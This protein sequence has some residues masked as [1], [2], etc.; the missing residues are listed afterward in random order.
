LKRLNVWLQNPDNVTNLQNLGKAIG[1]FAVKATELI[2]KMIEFG[3]KH[4]EFTKAILAISAAIVGLSALKVPQGIL[5][6]IN[7]FGK[8]GGMA[9]VL[10]LISNPI[11]LVVAGILAL[12]YAAVK[13]QQSNLPEWL[14]V[15][16][17][18]LTG[19][20]GM[21]VKG[22]MTFRQELDRSKQVWANWVNGFKTA[23]SVLSNVWNI[24]WSAITGTF[25]SIVVSIQTGWTNFITGIQT[26]WNNFV[27][28][29]PTAIQAVVVWFDELPNR[30]AFALGYMI[31]SIARFAVDFWNWLTVTVPQ[32]IMAFS[33]IVANFFT[34]TIPAF[35]ESLAETI[36]NFFTVVIPGFIVFLGAKIAEYF[37]VTIPGYIEQLKAWLATLPEKAMEV[38]NGI[39]EWFGQLPGKLWDII[40]GIWGK[41]V[42]AF[43]N[44]KTNMVNWGNDAVDG[45]VKTF[46]GL[47]EKL[48]KVVSQAFSD[49]KEKASGL[50]SSFKAGITSGFKKEALGGPVSSNTPYMVGENG[51]ELFVPSSSGR[52]I[53]NNQVNNSNAMTVN[54][55]GNINNPQGFSAE[56]IGQIINRQVEL[57]K[58]GAY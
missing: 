28:W 15:G 36:K 9:G 25:N 31:G 32:A 19:P 48:K 17:T 42:E 49:A 7:I 14:K 35:I 39:L 33:Q 23:L 57:S 1:E 27:S 3:A 53:P 12:A 26:A 47:G 6:I 4:P 20:V 50:W 52:I 29:I 8:I 22:F 21:V 44:L 18:A 51:P 45:I 2:G 5:A 13:I 40:T 54:I 58:M 24:A 46:T 56:E 30:L 38:V 34:V 16:L 10:K 43:N 37:T 41:V 55:Y 11:G